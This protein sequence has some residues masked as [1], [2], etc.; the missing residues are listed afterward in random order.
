MKMFKKKEEFIEPYVDK[1]GKEFVVLTNEKGISE[2]RYIRDLVIK[3]FGNAD[4]YDK[5]MKEQKKGK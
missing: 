5:K 3:V 2:V 4:E 1:D